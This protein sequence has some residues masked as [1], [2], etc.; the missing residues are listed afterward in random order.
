MCVVTAQTNLMLRREE[1]QTRCHWT[2]VLHLQYARHISG[3]SMPIIRSSRPYVCYYR[4]WCAMPWFLV[5]RGQMQGSR[6]CVRDEGCCSS[7]IPHSWRI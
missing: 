3:T 4:L 5:V 1:K 7:N 6:L 2:C